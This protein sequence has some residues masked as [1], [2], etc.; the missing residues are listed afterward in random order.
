MGNFILEVSGNCVIALVINIQLPFVAMRCILWYVLVRL[1][2]SDG[3][4][5]ISVTWL[6]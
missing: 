3:E 4:V 5:D 1:A 6:R 2:F